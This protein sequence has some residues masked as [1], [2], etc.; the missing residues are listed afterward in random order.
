MRLNPQTAEPV[1]QPATV[2]PCHSSA[3]LQRIWQHR[4]SVRA[5]TDFGVGKIVGTCTSLSASGYSAG[6]VWRWTEDEEDHGVSEPDFT[7]SSEFLS[8]GYRCTRGEGWTGAGV[9]T[10]VLCPLCSLLRQGSCLSS[11]SPLRLLVVHKPVG[12]VGRHGPRLSR[13]CCLT[14]SL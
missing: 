3:A 9:D 10:T 1:C 7:E 6:A 5:C 11:L 8:Q 4:G 12:Q 14:G 2:R 13:C